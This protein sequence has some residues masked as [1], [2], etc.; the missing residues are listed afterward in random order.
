[1]LWNLTIPGIGALLVAGVLV[2]ARA[3]D[4]RRTRALQALARRMGWSFHARPAL[5]AVPD[6]ERFGLFTVRMPQRMRGHLSGQVGDVHVAVFD[7]EHTRGG[8]DRPQGAE[9]TVVHVFA[10]GLDLPAFSLRPETVRHRMGDRIGGGDID[11]DSDPRFSHAY[12]LRGPDEEAIRE[13]FSGKV[14]DVYHR[15][16]D[17]STDAHGSD[18]LFWRRGRVAA[19]EE[20]PALVQAALD[21][22]AQLGRASRKAARV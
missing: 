15:H 18:L 9:Q 6:R 13:A 7:L 2:L 3:P 1:M 8:T 19:P 14:R 20:I 16:P 5:D 11:L 12:L 10:P 4:A 21:L 17:S 22:A